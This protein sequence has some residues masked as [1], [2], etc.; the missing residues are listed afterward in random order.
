MP[1]RSRS[2]GGSTQSLILLTSRSYRHADKPRSVFP[3]AEAIFGSVTEDL[4]QRA[5]APP[6][7]GHS[8]MP[9]VV[10]LPYS[11]PCALISAADID[12][13]K[14]QHFVLGQEKKYSMSPKDTFRRMCCNSRK[15]AMVDLD[16]VG[17]ANALSYSASSTKCQ[18]S[19]TTVGQI[20]CQLG[21][22]VL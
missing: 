6:S 22:N 21:D 3:H 4:V 10:R 15:S 1:C 17:G 11:P 12:R 7:H 8:L 18:S 20:G 19:L 2:G 16:R 13:T 9:P 14:H 5:I